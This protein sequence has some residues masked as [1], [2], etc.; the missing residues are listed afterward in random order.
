MLISAASEKFPSRYAVEAALTKNLEDYEKLVDEN[1]AA[2]ILKPSNQ[3]SDQR[4]LTFA[5]QSRSETLKFLTDYNQEVSGPSDSKR[6][7]ESSNRF[8]NEANDNLLQ[9]LI[10]HLHLVIVC[11]RWRFQ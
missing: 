4:D 11:H 6:L 10:S 9:F 8:Y 3:H 7:F 2:D 1:E 5:K